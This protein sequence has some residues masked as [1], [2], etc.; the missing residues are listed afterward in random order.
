MWF[1]DIGG[2]CMGEVK[3]LYF[4]M[5]EKQDDRECVENKFIPFDEDVNW[6]SDVSDDNAFDKEEVEV[7]SDE[8][9]DYI[10]SI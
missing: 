2:N 1:Q 10:S 7:V 5:L 9:W 8:Y 6:V 4:D 3:E